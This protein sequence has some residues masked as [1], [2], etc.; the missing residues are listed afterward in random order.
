MLRVLL[1]EGFRQVT[2]K[3]LEK[4]HQLMTHAMSGRVQADPKADPVYCGPVPA[5]EAR[6]QYS[7]HGHEWLST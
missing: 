5:S 7:V 4:V 3:D 6:K 1:V 2:I